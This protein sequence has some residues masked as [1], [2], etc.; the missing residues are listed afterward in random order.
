[1]KS[2]WIV[3]K[4]HYHCTTS[5]SMNRNVWS[6][7]SLEFCIDDDRPNSFGSLHSRANDEDIVS[8]PDKVLSYNLSR[9]FVQTAGYFLSCYLSV[10][11]ETKCDEG[12]V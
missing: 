8:R 11:Y 1:M 7:F 10:C 4:S 3:D 12:L 5:G 9:T 6:R 2:T